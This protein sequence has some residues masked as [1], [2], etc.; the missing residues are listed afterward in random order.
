MSPWNLSL[1]ALT[2]LFEKYGKPGSGPQVA[3]AAVIA[4]FGN[5]KNDFFR[6]GDPLNKTNGRRTAHD[7][8]LKKG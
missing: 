3:V 6:L 2:I 1:P 5:V 7:V 8:V 4:L